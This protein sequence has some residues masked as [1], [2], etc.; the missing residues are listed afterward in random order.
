MQIWWYFIVY[1]SCTSPYFLP[2]FL[3]NFL[4]FSQKSNLGS[5]PNIPAASF[6]YSLRNMAKYK[7]MCQVIISLF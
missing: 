4:L 6:S 2:Y 3:I 1:I 7:D 5:C